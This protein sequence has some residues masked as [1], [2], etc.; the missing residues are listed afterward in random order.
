M[1]QFKVQDYTETDDELGGITQE[2]QDIYIGEG[3]LDLLSGTNQ[4]QLQNATIE[5]STHV[6]ICDYIENYQSKI[7]DKMYVV[8]EN[9][10]Y[11]ITYVDDPVGAHDHLEIY[12]KYVNDYER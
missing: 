12:L 8:I 5:Q 1:I 7:K 3:Y 2:Y 11:F 4:N 9:R 6:L 10:R